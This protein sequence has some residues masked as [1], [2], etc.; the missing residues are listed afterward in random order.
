MSLFFPELARDKD[1]SFGF[2][3]VSSKLFFDLPGEKSSV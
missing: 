1:L 3:G 2:N